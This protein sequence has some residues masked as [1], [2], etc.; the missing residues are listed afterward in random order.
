MSGPG[1]L[2]VVFNGAS[3]D[4]THVFFLTDERLSL[5]DSDSEPDIYERAAGQT[6][7][8]SR[9]NVIA[10]GPSTPILTATTPASPNP[11]TTPSI[12]GQSDP[13]TS[14]KIYTTGE[15]SGEPVATGTA[16]ELGGAGIGVTVGAGTTTNF[17]ATATDQ[18]GDTSGCS[19]PLAYTQE[20]PPPTSSA[21]AAASTS[22][23][24][25]LAK[26]A[27]ALAAKKTKARPIEPAPGTEGPPT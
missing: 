5:A 18:N 17:R 13:L 1:R 27:P 15:C 14:L 25:R 21:P 20:V 2:P 16:V 3:D 23:R 22:A 4:G 9:G 10:L 8:V 7:L 6:R 26:K 19:A 24:R 11:S 12:Q